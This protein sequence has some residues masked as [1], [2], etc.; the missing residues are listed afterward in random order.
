MSRK[1]KVALIFGFI[2]GV[3]GCSD[4]CVDT[5]ARNKADEAMAQALQVRDSL[6]YLADLW[7]AHNDDIKDFAEDIR[8][9]VCHLDQSLFHPATGTPWVA[10]DPS[11]QFCNA[12]GETP[13]TPPPPGGNGDPWG[14]GEG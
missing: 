12:S 3:G 14:E 5:T 4:S 8:E 7:S 2:V 10:R 9:A 11:A 6:Y 13:G 1:L